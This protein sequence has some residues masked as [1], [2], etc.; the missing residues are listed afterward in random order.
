MKSLERNKKK[1]RALILSDGDLKGSARKF[2]NAEC[3][4]LSSSPHILLDNR[5]EFNNYNTMYNGN[6]IKSQKTNNGHAL[7]REVVPPLIVAIIIVSQAC[8]FYMISDKIQGGDPCPRKST[9]G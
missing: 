7:V 8:L 1:M 9:T 6:Y 4:V 5:F 2:T 3:G